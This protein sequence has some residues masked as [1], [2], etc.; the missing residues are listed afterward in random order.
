MPS[1]LSLVLQVTL[2]RDDNDREVVLV[3]HACQVAPG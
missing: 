3:L 2:V 1:Y